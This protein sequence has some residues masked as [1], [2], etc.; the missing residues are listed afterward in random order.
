MVLFVFAVLALTAI[1]DPMKGR[2]PIVFD[3]APSN[4]RL[5]R[6]IAQIVIR[7]F[8]IEGGLAICTVLHWHTS[9]TGTG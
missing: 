6:R 8:N 1:G 5:G 2:A 4:I 7:L 9:V 3:D